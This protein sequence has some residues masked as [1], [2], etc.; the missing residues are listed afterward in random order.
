MKP[1]KNFR[2]QFGTNASSTKKDIHKYSMYMQS[3]DSAWLNR[4]IRNTNNFPDDP[5]E[6]IEEDIRD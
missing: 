4:N 3:R 2:M 5:L 1:L 6:P